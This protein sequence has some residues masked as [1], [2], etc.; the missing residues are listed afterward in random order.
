MFSILIINSNSYNTG[1]QVQLNFNVVQHSRDTLLMKNLINFFKCGNIYK[2]SNRVTFV[3][4]KLLDFEDKI[5]PFFENFNLQGNKL[6]DF[7]KF[8]K[9]AKLMKEK[10][11]L[12][13]EGLE[14]I[15]IIISGK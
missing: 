12:T 2:T 8:K 9:I 10:I 14:K 13:N 1:Y 7:L 6:L 3:V 4:T 11:H 5:F 15:K